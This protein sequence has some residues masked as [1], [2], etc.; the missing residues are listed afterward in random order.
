MTLM[1]KL[2]PPLPVTETSASVAA[3]TDPRAILVNA[4]R[5][6]GLTL[7]PDQLDKIMP[8][9]PSSPTPPEPKPELTEG[10]HALVGRSRS[11]IG[12][13]L[14]RHGISPTPHEI[15]WL[16][17]EVA[18]FVVGEIEAAAKGRG[19]GADL[20]PPSEEAEETVQ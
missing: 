6:L 15:I 17:V 8:V 16:G 13:A 10:E 12:A 7:A 18:D 4:L 9:P 14:K 1:D 20:A 2:T 3:S 11:F 5:V 19:Q